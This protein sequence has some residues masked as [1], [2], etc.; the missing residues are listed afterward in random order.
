MNM[1]FIDFIRFTAWVYAI[2]I[3]LWAIAGCA[4]QHFDEQREL[5][6]EQIKNL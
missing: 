4:V 5:A 3:P 6:T 1:D 2:L